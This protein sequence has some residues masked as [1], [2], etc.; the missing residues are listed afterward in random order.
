LQQRQLYPNRHPP[1][2]SSKLSL[3]V[4]GNEALLLMLLFGQLCKKVLFGALHHADVES[5]YE[6]AWFAITD[7]CLA[8]T[9]I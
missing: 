6:R 1:D 5:L 3:L 4:R 2:A 7:A 8:M 9:I